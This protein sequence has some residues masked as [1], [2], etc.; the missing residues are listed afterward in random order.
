MNK[1][2]VCNTSSYCQRKEDKRYNEYFCKTD[3]EVL[4]E[5]NKLR[6]KD[7]ETEKR[8]KEIVEDINRRIKYYTKVKEGHLKD[9]DVS[10][11]NFC[12]GLLCQAKRDLNNIKLRF[13]KFFKE[14][15]KNVL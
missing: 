12:I 3:Y 2:G 5:L 7:K 14:N 11:I 10:G 6:E 13:P 9:K 8:L 1:Q 15:E 4:D